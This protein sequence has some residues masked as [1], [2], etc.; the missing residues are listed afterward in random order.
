MASAGEGEIPKGPAQPVRP[1][2]SLRRPPP[3]HRFGVR[4][5][6][7][8]VA[9]FALV[10]LL[11]R[12]I[13]WPIVAAG[14]VAGLLALAIAIVV[15]LIRGQAAQ[16]EALL[17]VLSVAAERRMPLAPGIEAYA[18]LCGV[19]YRWRARALASL[20]DAGVTLPDASDLVPGVLPSDAVLLAR[21]GWQSGTLARA[22]RD[23]AASRASMAPYRKALASQLL[24]IFGVLFVLQSVAAFV[25][26]RIAPRFE[27]T[28]ADFGLDLPEVTK[29]IFRFS[30]SPVALGGL[31]VLYLMELALLLYLPLAYFGMLGGGGLLLD[32]FYRRRH[33]RT[34]LRALAMAVEGGRPL[35]EA[36][37]LMMR[38]YPARRVRVRLQR[39]QG[40]LEQ[41]RDWIEAL[42]AR[43]LIRRTDA[44]VLRTAQRVGNL[45]WA[46]RELADGIERRFGYRAQAWL[47][48]LLPL[49]VLALGA[50]VFLVAIGFFYPLVKLI[51]NLAA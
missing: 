38:S 34:L 30:H 41:G 39:V 45:P 35:P 42:W 26:I 14:G 12:E 31:L 11:G 33:T 48:A 25:F 7:I 21:V 18:E 36:I 6:M 27:A 37:A 17:W 16:R 40:D 32:L 3:G 10:F 1:V 20:L 19:G 5:L 46:L 50:F 13:G 28:F 51:S 44:A 4:D 15:V 8:A 9:V 2:E 24:Y 23:A 49:A 43:R 29:L 47:Q 22:L